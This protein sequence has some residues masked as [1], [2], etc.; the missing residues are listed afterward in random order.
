MIKDSDVE[1]HPADP[2]YHDW[3]ETNYFGFYNAEHRLVGNIYTVFRPNVG[4]ATSDVTIWK[5][6]HPNGR[7][8]LYSGLHMHCPM[9]EKLSDYSL[10]S[11]L[12][13]KAAGV[14][15]YDITYEGTDDT[16][17]DLKI[18]GIMEPYD[19]NDPAMDPITRRAREKAEKAYDWGKAYASHFDM[20]THVTGQVTVRGETYPIDCFQPMDH[21]WGPRSESDLGSLAW[22][23]GNFDGVTIHVLFAVDPANGPLSPELAHGYIVENGEVT[24][25]V[26]GRMHVDRIGYQPVAAVVEV[27]DE[28][29]RTHVMH[30]GAMAGGYWQ[31]FMMMEVG[32]ALMRW[33]YNGRVGHGIY[34][35]G[36][37]LAYRARVAW[38]R[39]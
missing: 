33:T 14:R 7:D 36:T 32:Y 34:Q 20:A 24:G 9:P 2:N 19:I 12:S 39:P 28:K 5:G 25:L 6:F 16:R 1:F 31:P 30:A 29:G 4:A 37:S 18:R 11:G 38:G 27:E 26:G 35:E 15:S 10:T 3:A 23:S 13:L 17:L 8:R 21:S 22:L